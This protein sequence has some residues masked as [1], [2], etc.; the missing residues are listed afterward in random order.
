MPDFSL[1]LVSNDRQT[2]L[3]ALDYDIHNYFPQ[4]SE[5]LTAEKIDTSA[6]QCE[7][8]QKYLPYETED[9]TLFPSVLPLL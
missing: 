6:C 5:R 7:I 9:D 3:E 2:G 8:D 4:H 1:D